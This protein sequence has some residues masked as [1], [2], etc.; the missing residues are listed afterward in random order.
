MISP[1]L[2][3][4]QID[5]VISQPTLRKVVRADALRTIAAPDQQTARLRLFLMLLLLPH[6]EQAGSEQ[7][8]RAGAVL[9]LRAFVLTTPRRARSECT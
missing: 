5:A 1:S 7:R 4:R 8:H 2:A 6:V 9:V 3:E